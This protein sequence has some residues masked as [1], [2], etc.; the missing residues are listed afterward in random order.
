MA[1]SF[2]LKMVDSNETCGLRPSVYLPA[3][4]K[5]MKLRFKKEEH[6]DNN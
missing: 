5:T 4:L 1:R 2:F 3:Q 6:F